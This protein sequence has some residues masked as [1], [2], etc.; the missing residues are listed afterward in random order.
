VPHPVGELFPG[1]TVTAQTVT[2][3]N[4]FRR[5]NREWPD[6]IRDLEADGYQLEMDPSSNA[7]GGMLAWIESAVDAARVFRN[8]N[9]GEKSQ[10]YATI[11]FADPF[12]RMLNLTPAFTTNIV[13]DIGRTIA[14]MKEQDAETYLKGSD[15]VFFSRCERRTR[16]NN[17]AAF[18]AVFERSFE[19][20]PLNECWEFYRRIEPS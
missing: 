19:K 17:D 14:V 13:M 1:T 16:I 12:A 3:A 15:G 2:A 20:L 11:A 7:P 18:E 5:I 9:L 4:L 10:H 8:G 6:F